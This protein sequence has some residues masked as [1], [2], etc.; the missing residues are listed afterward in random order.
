MPTPH[1]T[2]QRS[3]GGSGPATA[4][5]A[6]WAA[7]TARWWQRSKRRAWIGGRYRPTSR[8]VTGA[9]ATSTSV[10]S[11]AS[12]NGSATERAALPVAHSSSGVRPPGAL[13]PAPTTATGSARPGIG[14]LLDRP[15]AGDLELRV[16]RLRIDEFTDPGRQ[17]P[18]PLPLHAEVV[19][20]QGTA[21]RSRL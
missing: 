20:G 8:P 21:Q 11:R 14:R 18:Q 15:V 13:T 17:H 5:H 1:T 12:T 16:E 6:S 7:A 2:A 9:T 19:A 10:G 4:S 3:G